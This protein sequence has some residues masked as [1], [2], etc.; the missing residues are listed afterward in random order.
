[1]EHECEQV[2]VC[3]E[4][5]L[6]DNSMSWGHLYLSTMKWAGCS[7]W[8]QGRRCGSAHMICD[9]EEYVYAYEQDRHREREKQRER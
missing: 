4:G 8:G 3:T 5:H 1:M 7:C 9:D 2:D 6:E